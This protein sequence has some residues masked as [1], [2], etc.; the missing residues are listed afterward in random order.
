MI[1][2]VPLDHSALAG[3][4]PGN[5]IVAGSMILEA[6]QAAVGASGAGRCVVWE[7]ARFV[8]PLRPEHPLEIVLES[9]G[10]H[11]R[12][13]CLNDNEVIVSGSV[14]VRD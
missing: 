9:R 11:I 1:F 4:F 5:P 8:S 2:S 7:F 14:V 12:F 10:S 6:V 13:K 3:H